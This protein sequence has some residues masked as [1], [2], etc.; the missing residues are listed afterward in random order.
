[1]LKA[2]KKK[3]ITVA[4]VLKKD[5]RIHTYVD[6]EKE[7]TKLGMKGD[8]VITGPK[9]ERY[10]IDKAKMKERYNELPNRIVLESKPV[11][12]LCKVVEKDNSF[13]ASWGEPMIAKKGDYMVYENGKA[14]YRIEK[15]IFFETYMLID[16]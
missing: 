1:M 2:I 9:G 7:T 8:V 14:S 11:E 10:T 6:G 16:E 15:G 4:E 5:T 3:F 13:I 12:I